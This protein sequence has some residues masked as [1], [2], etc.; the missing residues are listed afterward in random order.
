[1]PCGGEAKGHRRGPRHGWPRR[2][3]APARVV[4]LHE[5]LEARPRLHGARPLLLPDVAV[6]RRELHLHG[7]RL[8][9]AEVAVLQPLDQLPVQGPGDVNDGGAVVAV[10]Q[11]SHCAIAR[12]A[13]ENVVD[14]ISNY[15]RVV[16]VAAVDKVCGEDGFIIP[17]VLVAVH[18]VH[19]QAVAR[20]RE[21]QHIARPGAPHEPLQVVQDVH[22]CRRLARVD[23]HRLLLPRM[24]IVEHGN[25][26]P[27]ETA[28]L[29]EALGDQEGIV[30]RASQTEGL[31]WVV[32]PDA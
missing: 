15:D 3:P 24:D 10:H 9:A 31:A 29:L 16:A 11:D 12:N 2:Q 13:H 32:A 21:E 28:A 22:P 1:M 19:L 30:H 25:V 6:V 4:D 26:V 27:L 17:L 18:V 23:L 5:G 20:E 14:V 8:Q 7:V